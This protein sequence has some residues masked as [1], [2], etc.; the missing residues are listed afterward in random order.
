MRL[1]INSNLGTLLLPLFRDTAGFLQKL[2]LFHTRPLFHS[3]F[4][5]VPFKLS[6]RRCGFEELSPQDN[7]PRN[8]FR[9]S[10]A[11]INTNRQRY[12]RTDRQGRSR[13]SKVAISRDHREFAKGHQ[14]VREEVRTNVLSSYVFTARSPRCT[15]VLRQFPAYSWLLAKR[16]LFGWL[17]GKSCRVSVCLSAL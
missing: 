1:P 7:Y 10:S 8:Y 15:T 13:S 6:R 5:E 2:P 12:R 3:K 17:V 16:L 11:Y 9:S 4:G 14:G